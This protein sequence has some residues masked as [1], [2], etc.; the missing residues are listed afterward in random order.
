M[1]TPYALRA[2]A[3]WWLQV[4]RT[5]PTMVASSVLLPLGYLA[6]LGLGIGHYV[7]GAPTW[8]HGA[9]YAAWLAPGLLASTAAQ[10]GAGDSLWPVLGAMKWVGQYKAQ[11]ASPLSA[12][13]ALY[14]H[15]AYVASRIGFAAVLQLAVMAG[16]GAWRQPTAPLALLAAVL[17]G[18]AVAAPTMAFSITRETDNSFSVVNRFVITPMFL[19]AGTF[20]P[21]ARMPLPFQVAA[22]LT[23]IWH[24]VTLARGLMLP[25]TSVVLMLAN[26]AYLVAL[27]VLGLVVAGRLYRDRLA[28]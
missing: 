11:T 6:S 7:T 15:L 22:W 12:T 27:L 1:A 8:L 5:L 13:D 25:G 20:F 2:S 19:F 17:C 28:R 18:A 24:G 3:Q 16:F 10:A 26:T 23:P 21:T 4:R 9:T 14:G